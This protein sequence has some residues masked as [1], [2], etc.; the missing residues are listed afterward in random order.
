MLKY[1][2]YLFSTTFQTTEEESLKYLSAREVKTDK[3]V[4]TICITVAIAVVMVRYFTDTKFIL[5]SLKGLGLT[6]LHAKMEYFFFHSDNSNLNRLAWWAGLIVLFYLIVPAFVIK[7]GFRQNLSDYGLKFKGAFKEYRLY[8]YM[9]MI[10]LPIVFFF[11]TTHSFQE[12][13]PFFRP[14]PGE[15]LFPKFLVWEIFYFLQFIAVEFLFRGFMIHGTKQ[16]FGYYS[17]FI[18]MIPY[19]MIHFGKPFPE[20]MSAIAAGIILGTLSLKSKSIMLG[21]AIHYSVAL[22]MDILALWYLMQ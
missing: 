16:R 17:V 22:A 6:N 2:K 12:R 18:M 19:C 5:N 15:S 13:Y 8:I 14:F 3:K 20:I 4:F 21:V 1:F 11:S 9:L 10:M 7:Y